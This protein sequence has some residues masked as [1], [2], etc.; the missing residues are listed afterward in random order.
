MGSRAQ[1]AENQNQKL[2]AQIKELEAS[3]QANGDVHN[4]SE[5]LAAANKRLEQYEGELRLTRYERSQDYKSKYESPYQNAVLEAYQ[6]VKELAVYEKTPNPEDPNNPIVK[7]RPATE[8]DFDQIYNLPLGQAAEAAEEKFGR[9]A[10]IV[11]QHRKA[12]KSLAKA[13]VTAIE[14]HKNDATQFEQQQSAQAKVQEEGRNQMFAIGIDALQKKFPTLFTERDGDKSWNEALARGRQIADMAYGDRTQ[15]TPQQSAILDAQVYNRVASWPAL[16]ARNEY[17]ESEIKRRDTEDEQRR[18]SAPGA[19][20]GG[21]GVT[22]T[23]ARKNSVDGI[24][25]LPE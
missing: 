20:K 16:K 13:A 12:I 1:V 14:Q 17:L 24:D 21:A 25:D 22:L 5:Q 19:A 8:A 10:S 23:K 3:S 7:R 6:E 2:Q 9:S 15:M 18:N 4:L 11:L